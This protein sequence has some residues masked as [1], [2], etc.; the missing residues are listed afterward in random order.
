MSLWDHI[1]IDALIQ[2]ATQGNYGLARV[3]WT[4]QLEAIRNLP[5]APKP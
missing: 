5:E 3:K 1:P 2:Q 4:Q